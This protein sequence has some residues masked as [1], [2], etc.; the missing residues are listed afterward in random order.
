M[1]NT[2]LKKVL[3][4]ALSLTLMITMAPIIPGAAAKAS[5]EDTLLPAPTITID[6]NGVATWS[7]VE[8]ASEYFWEI[9][10]F[11]G[12]ISPGEKIDIPAKLTQYSKGPGCYT[13]TM[14]AKDSNGQVISETATAKY[15]ARIIADTFV[16]SSTFKAPVYGESKTTDYKFTFT[17]EVNA[18]V[19]DLNGDWY[20]KVGE[21]WVKYEGS[22]FTE[23]TYYYSNQLRLDGNSG[24]GSTHRLP[25]DSSTINVTIN[26][27]KWAISSDTRVY[28]TY[29]YTHMASPE[30]EVRK[31]S[32]EATIST[33]NYTYDGK[34]KTPSVTVKNAAGATLKNGTDYTV[35]YASGRKNVGSYKVTVTFKDDKYIGSKFAYFNINP[36]GTSISKL[37][38][39]KKAFTVKWK[40]QS[41]K[42]ATS[43]INGYQ[44]RYSTSSKMTNAKYKIVK[45]YKYT[46]KKMTKLKA[47][48]KYYVQVRTYKTV[49]GKNYY[50]SWSSIK[51]VKTK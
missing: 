32:P 50:S 2:I 31:E 49:S 34:A 38:R 11:G 25:N 41:A 8:G 33:T 36:K 13:L 19:P 43:T 10:N 39:A 45:G 20:K 1:R 18:S 3:A 5:A 16:A 24:T 37:Y 17:S 44:I 35:S 29:S 51:S 22:Q 21:E 14:Y 42:M 27:E 48:K 6:E 46:S 15:D 7:A 40:K 26:G 12:K 30:Y 23:G 4:F 47:K 9:S 28:D